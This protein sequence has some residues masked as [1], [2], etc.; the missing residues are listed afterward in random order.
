MLDKFPSLRIKHR[1]SD[2]ESAE[3]EIR[4]SLIRWLLI[5]LVVIVLLLHGGDPARLLRDVLHVP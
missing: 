5:A 2:G 3:I 1:G 4:P